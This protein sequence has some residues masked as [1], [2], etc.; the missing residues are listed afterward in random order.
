VANVTFIFETSP[1]AKPEEKYVGVM[2]YYIPTVCKRGGQVPRVLYLIAPM[3]IH[4]TVY[5]EGNCFRPTSAI[6]VRFLTDS[7]CWIVNGTPNF[8]T[9]R[10]V[11]STEPAGF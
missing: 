10:H 8:R 11:R 2:A 6:S 9:V 5:I 7:N 4:H 3:L 1:N